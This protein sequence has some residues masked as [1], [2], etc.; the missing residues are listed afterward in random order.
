MFNKATLPVRRVPAFSVLLAAVMLALPLLGVPATAEA[1][2][3]SPEDAPGKVAGVAAAENQEIS[4][5]IDVTWDAA[6][7]GASPI[8]D[9]IVFVM[10]AADDTDH[11][12]ETVTTSGPDPAP[13][14]LACGVAG[15][16]SGATY[17]VKVRARNLTGE[18]GPWS[19]TVQVTLS[20]N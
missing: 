14:E 1:S 19:D 11:Q 6:T 16:S 2:H 7:P 20:G 18:L 5:S 13:E 9:Y 10:N 12:T 8:T 4:G 17:E 3:S 15:L